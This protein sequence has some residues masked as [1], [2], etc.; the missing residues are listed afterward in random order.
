MQELL[1]LA[2]AEDADICVRCPFE[3]LLRS[4]F[5]ETSRYASAHE[6]NSGK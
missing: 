1:E 3:H 6:Y 2:E 4:A 5:D